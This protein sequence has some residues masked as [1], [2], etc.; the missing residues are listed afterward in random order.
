MAMVTGNNLP[1]SSYTLHKERRDGALSP[2]IEYPTKHWLDRVAR[3]KSSLSL[4]THDPSERKLADKT[5]D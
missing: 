3:A 1:A 2:T 5:A 4:K